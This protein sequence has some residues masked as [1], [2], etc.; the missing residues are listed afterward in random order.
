[1]APLAEDIRTFIVGSTSVASVFPDAAVPGAVEHVTIRE[2]PPVP[3]LW[4]GLHRK[5][6][7][8]DLS[9]IGGMVNSQWDVEVHSDDDA[10]SIA[11]AGAVKDFVHGHIGALGSRQAWSVKAEDHDEDY[12]P[13]GD[14]SEEGLYVSAFQMTIWHDST[15]ST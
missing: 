5:D 9:N 11:I 13:R 1:M 10:Q 6:E 2:V 3:R 12:I 14:A 8:L 15:A 7:E 4:Y